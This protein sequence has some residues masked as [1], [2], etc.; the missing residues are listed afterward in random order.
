[1]MRFINVL[2][3]SGAKVTQMEDNAKSVSRFLTF[4]D[5]TPVPV[6]ANGEPDFMAMSAED[7]ARFYRENYEEDAEKQLDSDIKDME[8]VLKDAQNA[9]VKGKTQRE[10]IAS[11]KANK[12]AVALAQAQ[13]DKANEIRK[14]MTASRI[15]ESVKKPEATWQA[16]TE[17]R[18]EAVARFVN[19]PK[20]EGRRGSITLPNGEE[21]KGR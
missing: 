16:G 2:V 7:G 5:G 8:K 4:K 15:A 10:K 20:V 3:L 14:A 13:V 17:A 19:A 11:H 12:E 6:D 1:M 9:K 21:I 18:N